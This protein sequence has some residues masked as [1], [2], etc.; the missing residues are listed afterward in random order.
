MN[1]QHDWPALD[2]EKRNWVPSAS[3]PFPA[4]HGMRQRSYQAAVPLHISNQPVTLDGAITQAAELATQELARLDAELGSSLVSFEPLL[5]RSEAASSS[6][7]ENLTASSRAIFSAEAGLK[8]GPNAKL[9][10]AN[11][12]ALRASV[13]LDHPAG[14]TEIKAMH[15]ALMADQNL[16]VAGEFRQEAVWIG[17]RS[18]TPVG[19]E[20]VAP[21]Y[22]R[23]AD[24]MDD[25]VMFMRRTDVA[26][27]ISVALAHGQFEMIHPFTDGNG[28]TGRALVQAMLR[29]RRVLRN[30]L[31]PVSAG[32]L[33][34]VGGYHQALGL[35]RKG[36]PNQIVRLFADASMRAVS[37]TRELKGELDGILAVWKDKLKVRR[38]SKAWP[39]MDVLVRKPVL[40]AAVA[41]AELGVK[42]PNIYPALKALTQVG[43]L[44]KENEY[45]QGPSWRAPDVLDALDRFAVR[46]GRKELR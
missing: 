39:L 8:T 18:D 34:D 46:A 5:L 28:R 20:F 17:T 6:Q 44:V 36:Q 23:I 15:A 4:G 16:H 40:N 30:V 37:N 19:A 33:A 42:T 29:E 11:T 9:I 1:S 35:Y 26:P 7:I 22:S 25:L 21:H 10:V 32:L 45:R 12:R 3:Y 31:V 27:L 41:S 38:D 43:I 24:L 13:G 2:Y 14:V